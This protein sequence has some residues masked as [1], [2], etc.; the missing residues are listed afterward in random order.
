[1]V[2]LK[3]RTKAGLSAANSTVEPYLIIRRRQEEE[4]RAKTERLRTLRLA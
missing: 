4:N 1:M 3:K 2:R